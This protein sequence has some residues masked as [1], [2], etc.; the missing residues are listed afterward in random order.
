MSIRETLQH[1]DEESFRFVNLRLGHRGIDPLAYL[2]GHLAVVPVVGIG[3]AAYILADLG[4][5]RIRHGA[6]LLVTLLVTWALKRGFRR[7]RPAKVMPA[8]RPFGGGLPVHDASF[9]SGDTAQAAAIAMLLH[10]E[11]G[12][13]AWVLAYP[14]LVGWG[15]VA[16]GLHFPG[17]IVAGAFVGFGVGAWGGWPLPG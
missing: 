14:A 11:G 13:G 4:A 3:T 12:L 2:A 16:L 1:K 8:R 6:V 17:D 15:R 5:T 7:R 9:P 10:L